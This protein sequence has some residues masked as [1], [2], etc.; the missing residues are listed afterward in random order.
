MRFGKP[1]HT[2]SFRTE[3][4]GQFLRETTYGGKLIENIT[5]AIARDVMMEGMYSAERGG[6]QVLGT[7]HDEVLTLR[8]KGTSEVKKLEAMVCDVPNWTEGM[9][10]AAKGF[11]CE[12]YAKG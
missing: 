10:L 4:H 6:Y 9:P 12:R 2:I 3:Y 7:V 8:A 5:Q 11:V 1:A